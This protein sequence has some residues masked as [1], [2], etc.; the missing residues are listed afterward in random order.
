MEIENLS[1][2]IDRVQL[3]YE[4]AWLK[5]IVSFSALLG[6]LGIIVPIAVNWFQKKSFKLDEINFEIRLEKKIET[7]KQTLISEIQEEIKT[8]EKTIETTI[9]AKLEIYEKKINSA[10]G[11][12][13][14]LEGN[15]NNTFPQLALE[16]YLSAIKCY[17]E[18]D[19]EANLY[20]VL[21]LAEGKLDLLFKEDFEN[22]TDLEPFCLE[23][24]ES[25]KKQND[26]GKFTRRI[27]F[28]KDKFTK[29][30]NRPKNQ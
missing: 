25:L 27:N 16:S 7:L 2:I 29:A 19:Y 8:L 23:I 1:L 9:T 13:Y 15:V 22:N 20:T 26:S 10:T 30:K 21:E 6:F 14:H 18:S 3:F 11:G 4:S 28:F 5:L 17:L 24:L 12:L